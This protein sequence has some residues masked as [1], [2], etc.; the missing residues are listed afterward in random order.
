MLLM[1]S[2]IM[3]DVVVSSLH[4]RGIDVAERNE[5]VFGHTPLEGH[6]MSFG[7]AYVKSS[8]GHCFHQN[9]HGTS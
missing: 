6:G 4:E 2:H 5:S 9:V 3:D 7:N 8:V 1:K